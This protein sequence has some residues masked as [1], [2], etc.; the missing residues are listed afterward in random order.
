GDIDWMV[1]HQANLRIMKGMAKKLG[2]GEEKVIVTI[3]RHANTS[4]ASIPLALDWG[5]REGKIQ[6]GHLLLLEAIGGG[7]TWGAAMVRW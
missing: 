1:P 6:P 5:R 2:F 7:L 3:G 4:A